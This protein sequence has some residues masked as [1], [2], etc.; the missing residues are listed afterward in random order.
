MNLTVFFTPSVVHCRKSDYVL[1][2]ALHHPVTTPALLW[3]DEIVNKGR[4]WLHNKNHKQHISTAAKL[5]AK[6]WGCL[7]RFLELTAATGATDMETVISAIRM[8]C[9]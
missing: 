7:R 1:A 5:A 3:L 8:V 4:I 9:M 2:Y 6:A